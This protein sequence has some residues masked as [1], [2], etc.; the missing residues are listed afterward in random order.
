MFIEAEVLRWIDILDA[1]MNEMQGV[2]ER[3][4]PGTFSERIWSL[5][6]RLYH[7]VYEEGTP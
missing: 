1:R 4:P 5:D 6:R 3:T 7:P 2:M